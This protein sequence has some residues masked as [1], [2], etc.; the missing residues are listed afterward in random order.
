ML[1]FFPTPYPDE[2]FYS[3]LCRYHL[4][5]GN[6]SANQTNYELWGGIEG[7]NLLLP[8]G[9]EFLTEKIPPETAITSYSIITDN[10]IFPFIKPF[11]P[12]NR[13]EII[14]RQM[15]NGISNN[16]SIFSVAGL[17]WTK[18]STLK[19]MRYCEQCVKDDISKY[20]ETYWHR[21]HQVPGI[22]ICPAHGTA[23][24]ETDILI[25]SLKSKFY[26]NIPAS[27][28]ENNFFPYDI[29]EKL[30]MFSADADWILKNGGK[31]GY[32]EETY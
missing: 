19:Y 9:I 24:T 7:K 4:R 17:A 11:I 13:A 6:T 3:V 32:S 28:K 21:L 12:Q 29:T 10:T 31:I 14:L 15:K 18:F 23:V 1:S 26:Q 20:G 2:I 25:S 5:S 16:V 30:A 27:G 22:Y 8:A